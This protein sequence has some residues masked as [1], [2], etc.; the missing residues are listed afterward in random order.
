MP[1]IGHACGHPVTQADA[2]S[3][4]AVLQ[5]GDVFTELRPGQLFALTVFCDG[6]HGHRI[7]AAPQEVLGEVQ[8][9][10]GE[11][12]GTG[13]L[14]AFEQ[15]AVRLLV[16]ADVEK[17]DNGLPE[18]HPLIDGPLVQGR[19]VI[20]MQVMALIDKAPKRFHA[21]L[22]NAVGIGLPKDG[23]HGLASFFILKSNRGQALLPQ[24]LHIA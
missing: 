19:V 10:A 14:C 16:K 12:P 5:S 1:G 7:I 8:R 24:V 23:G 18:V 22:A 13:H 9:G 3:L 4:Q 17:V 11:P 21:C 15:H 2:G 6:N 20:D